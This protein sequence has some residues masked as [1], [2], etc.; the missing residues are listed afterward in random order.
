MAVTLLIVLTILAILLAIFIHIRK[1]S[2]FKD[3]GIQEASSRHFLFGHI[4]DVLF[5]RKHVSYEVDKIYKWIV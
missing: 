3:H 1:F 5:K 4:P 2:Y